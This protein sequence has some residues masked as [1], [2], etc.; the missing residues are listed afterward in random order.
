MLPSRLEDEN[1]KQVYSHIAA[2]FSDTRY[3]QWPVVA[4]F[5]DEQPDDALGIDLGCG[6]G[7]NMTPRMIGFD[8]CLDLLSIG[9]E[10]HCEVFAADTT[11]VP[12]RPAAFDFAISIAVIHHLSTPSGRLAAVLQIRR[13][14]KPGA[15]FLIFVWAFEENASVQ[16]HAIRMLDATGQ[17]VLVPWSSKDGTTLWRYYHLFRRNEL[18]ELV[19]STEDMLIDESGYDR[20]NWFVRGHRTA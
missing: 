3:K 5:L 12:V 8:A 10:R 18:D 4:R 17:D 6:N 14:L 20:D 16:R 7:K 9:A 1:V 2:H 13:L 11:L 15:A 19:L